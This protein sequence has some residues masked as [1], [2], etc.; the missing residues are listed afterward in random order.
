M[1][2]EVMRLDIL[3]VNG[4]RVWPYFAKHHYLPVGFNGHRSFMAVVAATGEPVAFESIIRFPNPYIT[5]GWRG[6]RLVVLPDFQG[7]GLGGRITDWCGEYVQQ[8]LD[9]RFFVRMLHPR[10]GSYCEHSPLWIPTQGNMKPL[11]KTWKSSSIGHITPLL[12]PAYAYEYV[13]ASGKK[14]YDP[15]SPKSRREYGV[16]S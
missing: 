9:G 12:R 4:P 8:V 16:E 14:K 5:R 1:T 6:H 3:E 11:G 15:R 2:T 13:G 7:L 10:M